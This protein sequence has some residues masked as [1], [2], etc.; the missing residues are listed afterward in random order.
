MQTNIKLIGLIRPKGVG[1]TTF[2]QELG[3]NFQIINHKI[4]TTC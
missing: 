3:V 1:K 4:D 2:A